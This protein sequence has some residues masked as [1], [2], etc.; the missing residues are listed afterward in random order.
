MTTTGAPTWYVDG[1][2][3]R[4]DSPLARSRRTTELTLI[5]MAA[6][7]HRGRLRHHRPRHQR[8]DPARDRR[9]RRHSPRPAAV[10]AHRRPPR[11][12]GRRRHPVAPGRPVARHRVRHDH[13]ARRRAGGPPG[14]VEPR[15][16]RRVRR[17]AARRPTS[18][19]PG[20]LQ[21]AVLLRRRVPPPAADG[22]GPRLEHQRCPHL[23][24]PRT[25]QLPAGR[26]RRSCS[27]RSSS[28]RT[29]PI[30]AS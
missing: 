8:R 22:S 11:R 18:H 25:G 26:V 14:D 15:R 24:Q 21:L 28:R 19:R 27:S 23:G 6:L 3:R 12:T 16:H 30:D 1:D 17:H 13:P 2:E 4:P 9:V 20:A 7:D 29:S 5:I 10:R